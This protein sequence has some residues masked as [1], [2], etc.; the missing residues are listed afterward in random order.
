MRIVEDKAMTYMYCL[1]ELRAIRQR[2]ADL[3]EDQQKWPME[4]KEDHKALLMLT[5]SLL[6]QIDRWIAD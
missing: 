4:H 3:Q 2:I 6:G 5:K 1:A